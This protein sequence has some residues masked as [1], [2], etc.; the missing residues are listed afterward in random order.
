MDGVVRLRMNQLYSQQEKYVLLEVEIPAGKAGENADLAAVEVSYLNMQN[1]I[2]EKLARAV[3]VSYTESADAVVKATD[4]KVMVS[5]VQQ[6]SNEVNKQAL[7][8]RDSGKFDDAKKVMQENSTYLAEKAISLGS[9][10]APA[11]EL[12]AMADETRAQAGRID[13]N[14]KDVQNV[15]RKKM[16]EDQY[17]L[18]KQQK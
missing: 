2:R 5:A 14:E 1:K 8:L 6:V 16:K 18:E 9:A 15:L 7:S 11:P 12:K 13:S 4:K 10:A 17:K 3:S